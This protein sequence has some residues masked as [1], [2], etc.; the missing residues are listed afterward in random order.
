[1]SEKNTDGDYPAVDNGALANFIMS[2]LGNSS[3]E[4]NPMNTDPIEGAEALPIPGKG[5]NPLCKNVIENNVS[6]FPFSESIGTEQAVK[7][8]GGGGIESM[9]SNPESGTSMG[10]L[11]QV[12]QD[13]DPGIVTGSDPLLSAFDSVN[14][15]DLMKQLSG[16]FMLDVPVSY[17]GSTTENADQIISTCLLYTSDAADD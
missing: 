15:Q 12:H 7:L 3:A 4:S 13:V 17:G 16:G 9:P 1:M 2:S 5:N 6:N 8:M 14:N 10:S 11:D